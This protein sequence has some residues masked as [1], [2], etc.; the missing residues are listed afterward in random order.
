M[1]KFLMSD[2]NC[3]IRTPINGQRD[4]KASAAIREAF[5]EAAHKSPNIKNSK[6]GVGCGGYRCCFYNSNLVI[7]EDC[8][9]YEP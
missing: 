1:Y 5:M 3:E 2:E 8:P 7:F 4:V 9:Y 6:L